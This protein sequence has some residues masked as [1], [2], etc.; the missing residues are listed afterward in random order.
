MRI[1]ELMISEEKTVLDAMRQLDA[2]GRCILFVAPAGK[3]QAVV[4]DAD[5][6]RYI[7]RGGRLD[8]PVQ[9]MAN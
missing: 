7:L 8:G 1:E 5:V 3:L 6:R 2:T 4:T 9:E